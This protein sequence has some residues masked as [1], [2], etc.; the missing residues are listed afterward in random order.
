LE[1]LEYVLW[2]DE[3]A[4]PAEL[5]RALLDRVAPA[6]V[7][8]GAARVRVFVEDADAAKVFRQGV[9]PSGTLLVATV[10]FW[11]DSV[12][13][14]A[15]F[16]RAIR[17]AGAAEVAG[18]L[19]T[20]SVPLDRPHRDW[21]DGT[22]APGIGLVTV[23]DKSPLI[24]DDEFYAEWHGRHTPMTFEIHPVCLYIRNAVA[25]AVTPGAP[26]FRGIVEEAVP[27]RED[28][29]D[30]DRFFSAHGDRAVLRENIERTNA[31]LAHFADVPNLQTCA[32]GEWIVTS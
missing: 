24:G 6:V 11:L 9:G 13:E 8:L 22:R 19:V 32:M 1:K 25:R 3:A 21:P 26:S 29:L 5:E 17:D 30:F 18:Y 2:R 10:S 12:D 23:F 16:E 4:D 27:A 15:P 20:E 28:L 14:R 31:H 7:G